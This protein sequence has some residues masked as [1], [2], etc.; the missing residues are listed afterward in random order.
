MDDRAERCAALLAESFASEGQWSAAEI[1]AVLAREGG[2]LFEN[3]GGCLI[4]SAV[5]DEAEIW[6]IATR[7]ALRRQGYA[8]ELIGQAIA[9][10]RENGI[11]RL[12][13]EVSE[14]NQPARDLYT[15]MGFQEM[16]RRPAYYRTADGGRTDAV[17]MALALGD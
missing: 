3:A 2:Y 6:T 12:F 10:L 17:M 13:L 11:E 16:G 4:V 14:D 1:A 9:I 7:P 5:L 8:R 15:T